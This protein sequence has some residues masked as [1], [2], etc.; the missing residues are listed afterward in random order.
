MSA[1]TER[2]V[3]IFA[4]CNLQVAAVQHGIVRP[5]TDQISVQRDAIV[6]RVT[7]IVEAAAASGVNVICFQEAWSEFLRQY[8]YSIINRFC[9][10]YSK[11]DLT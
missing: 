5:T 1:P 6:K 4:A 11:F 9:S 2:K 7:K 8:L 10:K 3:V